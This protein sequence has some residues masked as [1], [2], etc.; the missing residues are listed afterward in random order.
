MDSGILFNILVSNDDGYSS[1]G[2]HTLA[3]IMAS[4]GNV[5]VV[6]PKYHQSAMSMAVR[7]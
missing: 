2:L 7:A 5:T 1:R 6:A 3:N 4:F